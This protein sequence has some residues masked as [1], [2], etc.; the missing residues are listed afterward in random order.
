MDAA[1]IEASDVPRTA[2]DVS[3]SPAMRSDLMIFM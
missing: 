3:L 1:A 2:K